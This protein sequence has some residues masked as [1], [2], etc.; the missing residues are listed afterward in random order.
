MQRAVTVS[1]LVVSLLAGMLPAPQAGAAYAISLGQSINIVKPLV[2]PA[3][4]TIKSALVDSVS[5]GVLQISIF[6]LVYKVAVAA[7]SILQ[8]AAPGSRVNITGTL[9]LSDP[10][11]IRTFGTTG[12]GTGIF[13]TSTPPG[14]PPGGGSTTG[15]CAS[16]S[17]NSDQGGIVET[18]GEPV[19]SLVRQALGCSSSWTLVPPPN[20]WRYQGTAN[21]K[22]LWR[23]WYYGWAMRAGTEAQKVDA[24]NFLIE[25]FERQIN[26]GH[27]YG[28]ALTTSHYQIWL[29]GTTAARLLAVHYND[30]ALLNA[31]GKWFRQEFALYDLLVRENSVYSPGFRIPQG[32]GP[33]SQLRDVVYGLV[34]GGGAAS[35]VPGDTSNF[36]KNYY[37]V[38]AWTLKNILQKGDNLGGAAQATRN[39][40]LPSLVSRLC[41]YSKGSDFV[42]VFP[43]MDEALDPL[44]WVARIGGVVSQ[45]P[46][47]HGG[48]DNPFPA[49]VL[50]GATLATVP[51]VFPGPA[52]PF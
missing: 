7:G 1:I 17:E 13:P 12:S 44:F 41:V 46:Y 38:G 2:N 14:T 8:S 42:Y 40:D 48:G 11:L 35:N 22:I 49:P 23:T 39:T 31:T 19:A 52:C 9:D 32:F 4:V 20:E 34:K 16:G 51:G 30:T 36:W 25:W 5:A 26:E 33:T 47:I 24:R 43:R 18:F 6:G 28:E 10:G 50:S 21:Y 29:H 27:G 15:L 3:N 45:A 37:N